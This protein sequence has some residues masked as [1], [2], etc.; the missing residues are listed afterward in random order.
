MAC[1]ILDNSSFSNVKFNI[2]SGNQINAM[3][4]DEIYELMAPCD[5]FIGQWVSSNVDAVLTSLLNNHPE[6]SNKKL[7]LILEPP[8]GNIN[9]SS[10][11]LNLVRNSSIDYKKI[12]NGI[13]NDDLINYFKATKRGNNFESIQEYIDNEGSS[14]NSIFNNLVL[15]KDINDKANLKN[16]L[17]Y[18]LYPM[19]LQTLQEYRHLEYSVTDGIPLTST[20]IPSSMSLAI[21]P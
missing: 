20:L 17:L 7:F 11:S 4:E 2:R 9:S 21:V 18:V 19:S 1:E 10:S 3:S 13:S 14:F 6:L 12:F 8:T 15:Y 16:E 5:A